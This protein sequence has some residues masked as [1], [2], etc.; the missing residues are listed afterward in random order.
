[1]TRKEAYYGNNRGKKAVAINILMIIVGCLLLFVFLITAAGDI[2]W[3]N[4]WIYTVVYLFYGK[5]FTG[6]TRYKLI[7]GVW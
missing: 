1:V 2:F 3:I 5:E 7:S 4:A 6:S